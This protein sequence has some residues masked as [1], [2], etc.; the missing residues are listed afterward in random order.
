MPTPEASRL[1]PFWVRR[2]LRGATRSERP[3]AVSAWAKRLPLDLM[4]EKKVADHLQKTYICKDW[5]KRISESKGKFDKIYLALYS[6]PSSSTRAMSSNLMV[7]CCP[8]GNLDS[9]IE[10]GKRSFWT[11][12]TN[13]LE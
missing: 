7:S 8:E 1:T 6:P 10:S 5:V 12:Y 3:K 2:V 13:L 11:S 9:S 4:D